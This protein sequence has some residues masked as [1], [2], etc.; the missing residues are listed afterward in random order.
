MT[1]DATEGPIPT[2]YRRA[3]TLLEAELG[4]EIVGL[5]ADSGY[6]FGFNEAAASVWRALEQ[7]QT[8]A[9][10]RDALLAEYD[11]ESD[12]CESD[13]RELLD[14]MGE[15]GLVASSSKAPA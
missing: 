1:V 9:Q 2:H 14:K 10:L 8:F 13:L 11:V 7:P 12:R 6:C 4:G 3:A 5:D 15:A